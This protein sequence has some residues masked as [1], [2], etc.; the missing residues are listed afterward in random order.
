MKISWFV[1]VMLVVTVAATTVGV[2]VGCGGDFICLEVILRSYA[3]VLG[4]RTWDWAFTAIN[5]AGTH[6]QKEDLL[7]KG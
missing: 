7:S 2:G 3:F 1:C 4:D 6:F 5:D